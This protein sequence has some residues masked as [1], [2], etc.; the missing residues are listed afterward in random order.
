[1]QGNWTDGGGSDWKPENITAL[2]TG[3]SGCLASLLTFTYFKFK[4]QFRDQQK[5][6]IQLKHIINKDGSAEIMVNIQLINDEKYMLE[7]KTVSNGKGDPKDPA[8]DDQL[9]LVLPNPEV[10]SGDLQTVVDNNNKGDLIIGQTRNHIGRDALNTALK[11]AQLH[12]QKNDENPLD[13]PTLQ[14]PAQPVPSRELLNKHPVPLYLHNHNR[15]AATPDPIKL[16]RSV[17]ESKE[18]PD[19][20]SIGVLG[21][22]DTGGGSFALQCADA[23]SE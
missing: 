22:T 20:Y 15:M 9:S 16:T 19:V 7:H 17:E 6:D 11:F 18:S 8:A 2:A 23:T 3:I 5:T 12:Y 14:S 21:A 1:M 4:Q 10:V 13:V